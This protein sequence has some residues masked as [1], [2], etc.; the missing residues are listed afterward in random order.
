MSL[1]LFL[2]TGSPE[3]PTIQCVCYRVQRFRPKYQCRRLDS[4]ND[5]EQGSRRLAERLF[6]NQVNQKESAR[7]YRNHRS[8]EGPKEEECE[9]KLCACKSGSWPMDAAER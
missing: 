5:A 9:G 2:E 7:S 8:A 4:T 1:W 3:Q 6:D